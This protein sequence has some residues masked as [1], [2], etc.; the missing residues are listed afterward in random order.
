MAYSGDMVKKYDL[1][2]LSIFRGFELLFI[3]LFV[4]GI[5]IFPSAYLIGSYTQYYYRNYLFTH[6]W[7]WYLFFLSFLLIIAYLLL[8]IFLILFTGSAVRILR[9][10]YKEGYHTPSIREKETYKYA[11]YYALYRP[12]L[13]IINIFYIP[14][15]FNLYMKLLG[16]KLGKNVMFG[17]R[18]LIADPCML[19]V[20]DDVLI[21][22]GAEILGHI[23]EDKNFIKKTVIGDHCLVGGETLVF[24]GVVMEEGSVLAVRAFLPKNKTLKAWT[25]YGG[26]PAKEIGKVKIEDE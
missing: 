21:G 10:G 18:N 22:G 7:G 23:T 15:L 1:S 2:P 24:P 13:Q 26:V 25:I 19:E 5:S 4:Y 11:L 9:L 14:P 8:H 17:G 6:G 3:P 16:A 20:G 12:T